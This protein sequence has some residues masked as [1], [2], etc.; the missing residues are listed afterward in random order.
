MCM[1]EIAGYS[2]DLFRFSTTENQWGLEEIGFES[3][4]GSWPSARESHGMASVGSYVYVFGGSTPTGEEG[5]CAEEYTYREADG[6]P[7][8][9]AEDSIVM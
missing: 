3:V 2:N 8:S 7:G 5:L 9:L 1:L 6:A 4:E